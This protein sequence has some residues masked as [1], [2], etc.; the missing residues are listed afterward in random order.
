MVELARQ[1]QQELEDRDAEEQQLQQQVDEGVSKAGDDPKRIHELEAVRLQLSS[2]M[3]G[4]KR[5]NYENEAY[6]QGQLDE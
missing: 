4:Y 2:T 6:E 5:E 1:H 3:E